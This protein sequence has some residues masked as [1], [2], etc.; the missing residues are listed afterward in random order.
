MRFSRNECD[1]SRPSGARSPGARRPALRGDRAQTRAHRSP[2][3]LV[4]ATR[5]ARPVN[6]FS[7]QPRPAARFGGRTR[8]AA[9]WLD[10]SAPLSL[11]AD[12]H[13]SGL[14]PRPEIAQPRRNA[15]SPRRN[16]AGQ[17]GN[18]TAPWPDATNF[19]RIALSPPRN[20]I[21]CP[22]NAPGQRRDTPVPPRNAPS[23]PRNGT[24]QPSAAR[25]PRPNT[26][27]ERRPT[28]GKT[29][30]G[31]ALAPSH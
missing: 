3:S 5:L 19:R 10:R 26:P 18:S 16:A 22:R 9:G 8:L 13:R 1:D 6:I 30:A 4:V 28:R 25:D 27:I 12:P 31:R 14:P 7:V 11:V 2:T 23:P 24:R 15:A 20:T 17:K 21:S 29:S